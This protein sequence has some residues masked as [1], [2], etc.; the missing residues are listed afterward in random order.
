MCV[1]VM[2][3]WPR[4]ISPQSAPYAPASVM[5]ANVCACAALARVPRRF[6]RC[7]RPCS[8]RIC[9]SLVYADRWRRCHAPLF[10]YIRRKRVYWKQ[11]SRTRW[12]LGDRTTRPR[13][14]DPP[15]K[16]CQPFY[17][18]TRPIKTF[19]WRRRRTRKQID[20][21]V[22]FN[23][24]ALHSCRSAVPE[25]NAVQVPL[26]CVMSSCSRITCEWYRLQMLLSLNNTSTPLSRLLHISIEFSSREIPLRQYTRSDDTH[27]IAH[28][29][30]FATFRCKSLKEKRLKRFPK[31]VAKAWT[32]P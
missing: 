10:L 20:W 3:I 27:P 7:R 6:C 4:T 21:A 29:G 24:G 30:L 16:S 14:R 9:S 17:D 8:P 11:R 26:E 13:R 18:P 15:I 2:Y 28:H 22:L 1:F 19:Y 31:R 5:L 25:C 23:T 32:F 12:T